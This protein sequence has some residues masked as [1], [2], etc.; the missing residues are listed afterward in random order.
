MEPI[1]KP[2]TTLLD[3][4]DAADYL[5]LKSTTLDRWRCDGTGPVFYK[6]GGRCFYRLEDLDAFIREGRSRS[7][8]E[9][10]VRRAAARARSEAET[11]H[12]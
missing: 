1:R 7:A 6:L 9:A 4:K 8:T 12:E 5:R 10:R 2:T 3:T 11:R